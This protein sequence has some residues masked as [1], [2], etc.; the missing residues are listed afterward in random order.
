[1]PRMEYKYDIF[2]DETKKKAVKHFKID[3]KDGNSTTNV[4]AIYIIKPIKKY[5]EQYNQSFSD[6]NYDLSFSNIS[7]IEFRDDYFDDMKLVPGI[8]QFGWTDTLITDLSQLT[9][10]TKIYIPYRDFL[11]NN[12]API[13]ERDNNNLDRL[14]L[15]IDKSELVA[16]KKI[17]SENIFALGKETMLDNESLLKIFFEYMAWLPQYEKTHYLSGWSLFQDFKGM[18]DE[19][20]KSIPTYYTDT[21]NNVVLYKGLNSFNEPGFNY[22]NRNIKS[23]SFYLNRIAKFDYTHSKI[24]GKKE[25]YGTKYEQYH[26]FQKDIE[27]G[28]QPYNISSNDNNS[29]G[30][31][32]SINDESISPNDYISIDNWESEIIVPSN[33][34]LKQET[35]N[36]NNS[37]VFGFSETGKDT[38]F[39]MGLRGT[40]YDTSVDG[41]N[42]YI[43]ID[44]DGN[45]H[46]IKL[47]NFGIKKSGDTFIGG[48]HIKYKIRKNENNNFDVYIFI[49]NI[50]AKK[51]KN[52]GVP[53]QNIKFWGRLK[54]KDGNVNE[55]NSLKSV[56]FIY[57]SIKN[58]FIEDIFH[59]NNNVV[60]W[61]K[62]IKSN[63]KSEYLN[64]G[65]G[66]SPVISLPNTINSSYNVF[67]PTSHSYPVSLKETASQLTSTNL[68]DTYIFK[69]G[70][71]NKFYMDVNYFNFYNQKDNI[72][73]DLS[74]NFLTIECS[75]ENYTVDAS[76]VWTKPEIEWMHKPEITGVIN[77]PDSDFKDIYFNQTK[78][79]I[80]TKE[81]PI[82]FKNEELFDY[83]LNNI[84][85]IF[86]AGKSRQIV[87]EVS[88]GDFDLSNNV[89][90]E[91]FL[92]QDLLKLEVSD[93]LNQWTVPEVD[94]MYKELSYT[95]DISIQYLFRDVDN[96]FTTKTI[97]LDS[98]KPEKIFQNTSHTSY[99]IIYDAGIN[100]TVSLEFINFKKDNDHEITFYES[101]DYNNYTALNVY[102]MKD[103]NGYFSTSA[104]F[105]GNFLPG[106]ISTS[107]GVVFYNENYT[108]NIYINT[109][110]RY[111]KISINKTGGT[112]STTMDIA[113]YKHSLSKK[114]NGNIFPKNITSNKLLITNKRYVKLSYRGIGYYNT[115]E[116]GFKFKIFSYSELDDKY[117]HIFPNT[118]ENA[119]KM[120]NLKHY[121]D[122]NRLVLDC[123][124]VKLTYRQEDINNNTKWDIKIHNEADTLHD[125]SLNSLTSGEVFSESNKVNNSTGEVYTYPVNIINYSNIQ[126]YQTV[127]NVYY[128]TFD[129]G[130]NNFIN[131]LFES[132]SLNH[133]IDVI[134][135]IKNDIITFEVSTDN[136]NWFPISNKW[137]HKSSQP[138]P[139][140]SSSISPHN[141]NSWINDKDGFILPKDKETALK[142]YYSLTTI[143]A[144]TIDTSFNK[145]NK[146]RT[147]YRYLKISYKTDPMDNG[148]WNIKVFIQEDSGFDNGFI[149]NKNNINTYTKNY[150]VDNICYEISANSI[151]LTEFRDSDEFSLNR[152]PIPYICKYD[153]IIK[154]ISN[155]F[156]LKSQI[157]TDILYDNINNDIINYNG[158]RT[159]KELS[160]LKDKLGPN[161]A[162]FDI[163][164]S[165]KYNSR[166]INDENRE[167][168]PYIPGLAEQNFISSERKVEITIPQEQ[169][170]KLKANAIY[171]WKGN[172]TP[173]YIT[174]ILYIWHPF[175]EKIPS[176]TEIVNN[177]ITD[178]SNN[179]NSAGADEIIEITIPDNLY[180]TE[181]LIGISNINK[182]EY[183]ITEFTGEYIFSWSYKIF[184]PSGT[185]YNITPSDIVIFNPYCNKVNLS[186]YLK[187][188]FIYDTLA[189][190]ITYID[191]SSN[192]LIN[193]VNDYDKIN[194]SL[195]D[196]D[197]NGFNEF[198]KKYKRN[199]TSEGL[200]LSPI[201][202]YKIQS[203]K[204]Y[205]YIWTPNNEKSTNS[206]GWE[207][208]DDYFGR[209][210]PRIALT[211]YR[212]SQQPY[213]I[214]NINWDPNFII[215]NRTEVGYNINSL[216]TI[217]K[218]F[219][220]TA[221][222]DGEF[223][224]DSQIVTFDISHVDIIN[225]SAENTQN[226]FIP[227]PYAYSKN[228]VYGVPYLSRW[229]FEIQTN[230]PEKIGETLTGNQ[231]KI[232]SRVQKQT[233]SMGNSDDDFNFNFRFNSDHY[234]EFDKSILANYKGTRQFKDFKSIGLNLGFIKNK[235]F[236]IAKI[237]DIF[238]QIVIKKP[239]IGY[240]FDYLDEYGNTLGQLDPVTNGENI[241]SPNGNLRYMDTIS[242]SINFNG[243]DITFDVN[244]EAD[245]LDNGRKYILYIRNSTPKEK[246]F[247][248]S[249]I[250]SNIIQFE[251][252]EITTR[253]SDWY[254]LE[255][256]YINTSN[257]YKYGTLF[258]TETILI[259]NEEETII[260]KKI[261]LCKLCRTTTKTKNATNSK[262][263]YA[264]RVSVNF[265][266]ASKLI[267]QC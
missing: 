238:W 134:D 102:W 62:S 103:S 123:S 53:L 155:N 38:D 158:K 142:M 182:F 141:N 30:T 222:S 195:F 108:G 117:G 101:T 73:K 80:I 42:N 31:F 84:D 205:F 44:S 265:S 76:T 217:V 234:L 153:Y 173:T 106:Q 146:L 212:F 83:S 149:S 75:N 56:S 27:E 128:Y 186:S 133:D 204:L 47:E 151:N 112:T 223:F 191:V 36:L 130:E 145:I 8:W 92:K 5:N 120:T 12:N 184:Q 266:L 93:T 16:M 118:I 154:D 50:F 2:L 110:S 221:N 193:A 208:P 48:F 250:E 45:P 261:D 109:N 138:Y 140:I 260:E 170:N 226:K 67:D 125:I 52:K 139:I 23:N 225:N 40:G 60:T 71:N 74:N 98:Q 144:N 11:Y 65:S 33:I 147:T 264:K 100:D 245:A 64:S 17:L 58:N 256:N 171:F 200:S 122:F 111:L 136:S 148:N 61:K 181:N 178:L 6:N 131:L 263:R 121:E 1:M 59:K 105:G 34:I 91:T 126:D 132:F 119:K 25:V 190:K 227:N 192:L 114:I 69:A 57:E 97:E 201:E 248:N 82:L 137:M 143:D 199:L 185:Y 81:T 257:Q 135:G 96:S 164:Q 22:N 162:A 187:D 167:F 210:D 172:I 85:Y 249:F 24:S 213:G 243:V 127:N 207:L 196:T 86:D 202:D 244:Q 253:L 72:T 258:G 235:P 35:N 259:D 55:G 66:I 63:I 90:P 107:K 41:K 79:S 7:S 206:N 233:G 197:I 183:V 70:A 104:S 10:I 230:K 177:I 198:I 115:N 175:S 94:W 3:M 156:I 99:N 237:N 113:V 161:E 218:D 241:I 239:P 77:I 95:S 242:T 165:Y 160:L 251:S 29:D 219:N 267:E 215:N 163:L 129:A 211:P 15:T 166:L 88:G 37:G 18:D 194:I 21:S 43:L 9:D 176:N 236:L 189:P 228:S 254:P 214:Q 87:I 54:D 26:F 116:H 152:K 262:M 68:T 49:N 247:F 20:L 240:I 89:N 231:I 168:S 32:K 174:L 157:D 51:I 78:S 13:I 209:T 179:L 46:K 28:Q 229:G 216:G 39:C 252:K 159:C 19:R 224:I 188:D 220:I 4:S 150:Q 180:Y 255:I 124:F 246:I 232:E 14:F 203:V 169:I